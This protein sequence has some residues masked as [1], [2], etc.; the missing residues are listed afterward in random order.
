MDTLQ[1][2]RLGYA[3][4]AEIT[5]LDVSRPLDDATIAEIRN[6]WLDQIVLCIPGQNLD[7]AAM[8]AFCGRFGNLDNDSRGH[9]N[10]YQDH[11]EIRFAS[12]KPINIDGR[13]ARGFS[14]SGRSRPH[15]HSD[16]SYLEIPASFT[17]LA[18][19]ELPDVGGNTMFANQYMAYEALSPSLQRIIDPLWAV[20]DFTLGPGYAA[21]SPERQ[22]RTRQLTPP[23]VQPVVRIHPETGRKALYVANRVRNFVGMTEEETKPLL[24]FL[25]GHATSHEFVYR[26]RWALDDLVMW[27]NRCSL[28]YAVSDYDQS[29]LRRMMR[30]S[31]LG[32]KTGHLHANEALCA[33]DAPEATLQQLG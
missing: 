22:A 12:N 14:R 30:C 15:W 16:L 21:S 18:A 11:P 1:T 33:P 24:D 7:P 5:G 8:K 10:R 20:H 23:V 17:F 28:H 13:Q 31:A 19:K 4:G 3:L 25:V 32:Q 2:R 6:L 26:H 29:Q 9:S 27:D